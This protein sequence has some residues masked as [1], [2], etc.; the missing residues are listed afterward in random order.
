M[1]LLDKLLKKM[2]DKG[3][4]VLI[5]TQMTKMLDIFEDFCVMRRYEYCRID[6]NTSY[7][8]REDCIDA[9]NKVRASFLGH[10]GSPRP[11]LTSLLFRFGSVFSRSR[12]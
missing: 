9:Y 8:S 3:H 6:G 11:A 4:R 1:V 7:E 5:F 12:A 10:G 2:F